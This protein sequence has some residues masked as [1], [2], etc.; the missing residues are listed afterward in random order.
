MYYQAGRLNWL[1]N[2]KTSA[3]KNFLECLKLDPKHSEANYMMAQMLFNDGSF[4]EAIYH[5]KLVEGSVSAKQDM[6]KA[7]YFS[8]LQMNDYTNSL[9]YL[10]KVL[11]HEKGIN[12]SLEKAFLLE[13]LDRTQDSLDILESVAK[14][15]KNPEQMTYDKVALPDKIKVLKENLRSVA[16]AEKKKEIS[17]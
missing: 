5:F 14:Q 7:L 9:T 6:Y 15:N 3:Y 4:K 13:K 2:E 11:S 16:T 12:Y 8:Y 10:N 17:K 1:N